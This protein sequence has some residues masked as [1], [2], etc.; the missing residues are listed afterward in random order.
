MSQKGAK[1]NAMRALDAQAIP[2]RVVTFPEEI[3][4]A[5]GVAEFVGVEPDV[6][7]KTLVVLPPEG[8]PMLVMVDGTRELNLKRVATAV[9]E[10]RVRMASQREAEGL[11]HLKVGGISALALLNRPFRVFIDRPCLELTNVYVSA[12]ERGINIRLRVV[13]LIHITH[14]EVIDA[15]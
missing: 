4:S 10:K 3:H 7:Y 13:D 9:G 6:V 14:A 12:G 8:K 5:R 11:T 1:N 2:Y 15:T